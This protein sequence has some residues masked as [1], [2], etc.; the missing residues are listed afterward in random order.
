MMRGAHS[1]VLDL[2]DMPHRP[3]IDIASSYK[4]AHKEALLFEFQVG[5]GQL[6]CCTLCLNDDDPA[7]AWL[8]EQVLAYAMCDDFC[9]AQTL[10][11]EQFASLCTTAPLAESTNSNLAMNKNDITM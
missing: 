3:I 4:N 5:R 7:A 9:P 1:A 11:C 10:S 8:R 6:L 2:P